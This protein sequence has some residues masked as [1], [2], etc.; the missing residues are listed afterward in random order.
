VKVAREI[1]TT[2]RVVGEEEG[3]GGKA[4]AL[5]TRVAGERMVTAT[6][7]V[8]VTKMR[9]ADKEEGNCKGGKSDGNGKEDGKGEQRHQ[10]P[11]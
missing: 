9:E 3:K 7:R 6:K 4:M 11:G 1:T 8:M 2:M 10:Q 5:A